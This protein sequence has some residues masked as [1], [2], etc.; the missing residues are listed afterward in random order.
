M[1]PEERAVVKLSKIGGIVL[2]LGIVV[3]L[4]WVMNSPEVCTGLFSNRTC[5]RPEM[6]I[7]F[8]VG[9]IASLGLAF[10]AAAI[11]KDEDAPTESED[12]T[13]G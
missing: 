9:G 3:T 1:I 8:L 13:E 5:S 2:G 4:W 10:A 11:W 7:R 12:E 6:F